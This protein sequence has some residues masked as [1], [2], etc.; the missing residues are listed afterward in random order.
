M[1]SIKWSLVCYAAIAILM[2][3]GIAFGQS[4]SPPQ[5]QISYQL[6]V[7]LPQMP[8]AGVPLGNFLKPSQGKAVLDLTLAQSPT[9]EAWKARV[10]YNRK[11][12]QHGLGLDPWPKRNPLNA[13]VSEKR[14]YDGY[15]VANFA[16]ES[17]PG[18][19][20]SGSLYR[21]VNTVGLCPAVLCTHG[22]WQGAPPRMQ[23][24]MQLRGATLARMGAVAITID[25]FG[26]GDNL[27]Q[28]TN[29]TFENV[30]C[31]RMAAPMQIWGLMRAI[32]FLTTL[33]GV[34][35]KRI[36]VTGESGGGT[37]AFVVT[38][39]D[40]RISVC[41]PVVMVSSYMFGGCLC[42]SGRPMHHS[43]GHFITNTEIAAMAA[44]RQMLVVSDGNDWTQN[45]PDIEFPFLQKI[46]TLNGAGNN[47]ENIH[48]KNEGHDYG[49][50]K[51]Q[52]MYRFLAGK[53][54]LNLSA[55][56]NADGKLDESKVTIEDGK[57]M[58]VWNDANPVPA[59][60]LRT[61]EDVEAALKKAQR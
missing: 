59:N 57:L 24:M 60:V 44:P 19:Y 32:D 51:R 15:S 39:L 10:E 7:D 30:H 50:S 47:V 8:A 28:F 11:H 18:F 16:I 45:T 48:L 25:M 4:E 22:H 5:Q 43:D 14:T 38:A 9:L 27:S 37:Q 61:V 13:I 33:D 2:P 42:E 36:A 17:I 40:P 1:E 31:T 46:Y 34:D 53:F 56:E 20:T 52:A 26:Y 21:P 58:R 55:A 54:M 12:I 49:P 29:G 23:E 3:I 41:V 6:P 35:A